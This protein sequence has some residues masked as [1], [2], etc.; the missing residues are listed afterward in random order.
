MFPLPPYAR[1]PTG[2]LTT[3]P[4]TARFILQGIAQSSLH[5]D[6]PLLIQLLP[7]LQDLP[8]GLLLQETIPDHP[9]ATVF[10]ATTF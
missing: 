1:S 10:T 9:K 8:K 7:I 2:G 4:Q 3:I 5:N 6:F